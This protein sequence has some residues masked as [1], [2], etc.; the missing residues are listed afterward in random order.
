MNMATILL[1]AV[2]HTAVQARAALVSTTVSL[3]YCCELEKLAEGLLEDATT[4]A[5]HQVQGGLFLDAGHAC[6]PTLP[7][8]LPP[9]APHIHHSH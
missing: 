3:C 8:G 6:S 4:Q 5:Q 9:K 7:H 1:A 2:Q